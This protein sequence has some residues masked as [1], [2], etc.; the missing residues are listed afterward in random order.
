MTDHFIISNVLGDYIKDCWVVKTVPSGPH[1]G[2]AL[3]LHAN[4]TAA[5]MTVRVD[6][7]KEFPQHSW[8]PASRSVRQRRCGRGKTL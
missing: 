2:I 3:T 5:T 4:P 6:K 8:L 1:D 7:A